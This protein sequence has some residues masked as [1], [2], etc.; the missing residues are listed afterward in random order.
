LAPIPLGHP[1][2]GEFAVSPDGS[3]V[4]YIGPAE[5]GAQVTLHTGDIERELWLD[6]TTAYHPVF[7]PDGRSVCLVG[8]RGPKDHT[9]LWFVD[10][11]NGDCRQLESTDGLTPTFPA[12]SPDGK[13]IAF[14]D[15]KLG[16]IWTVSLDGGELTRYDLVTEDAPIAW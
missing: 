12:F 6:L 3:T 10:L 15:W 2:G 13:R 8:A 4:L 14:R 5:N 9:S 16:H 7:S 1:F 11:E